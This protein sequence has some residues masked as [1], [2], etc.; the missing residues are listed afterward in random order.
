PELRDPGPAPAA[1]YQ[2]LVRVRL[3]EGVARSLFD[4]YTGHRA[5]ERGREETGWVLL[6]RREVDEAVI[7]A[8]LPAGAERDA[9]EAHVVF[10]SEAQALASRIVR[11]ADKRLVL[12]GVV[13]THPGS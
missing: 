5:T 6:G 2:P 10:N 1:Q 11:Q 7:L 8:T 12:I 13:H 3:A 9:G 4:E